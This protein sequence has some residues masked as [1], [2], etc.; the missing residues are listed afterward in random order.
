[1]TRVI[2]TKVEIEGR[3]HE[4]TV[5][6]EEDEPKAWEE[7]RQF[8]V[9]GKGVNRVDGRERVTGAARYTYDISLPG[10]LSAAVL[11]SPHAHAR[12][13]SIDTSHAAQLPGVRAIVS[14]ENTDIDWYKGTARL[15]D[16]TL[17]FIGDDVAAVAADDLDIARD[18]LK[19]IKVEYE[20]LPALLT[21][22]E[23]SRPGAPEIHPRG[24]IIQ[25]NGHNG[26]LYTRGSV[27][28]GFKAAEVTVE[29]TYRTSTQ[30]HNS[31]ETH[32]S[33]A[34]WEGEE[35]TL[36][37]STQYIFGV[38]E[39]VAKALDMPLSKV[40]VI[41]EYMGGGFGSKGSTFKQAA[42]A[43]LLA[44]IAQRPVKLMLD[45]REENTV[46]GNRGETVQKIRLGAT[47][48]GFLTAI[49]LEAMTG[50]GIYA[51]WAASVAGPAQELYRC[52]NVRTLTL[53]VRTNMGSQAAFRAPGY[54]EGMF[55]LE[56]AVDDLCVQAGH[57]P[58]RLSAEKPFTS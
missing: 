8:S 17:R 48:D 5:V 29:G 20:V 55:A 32:G 39:R 16:S 25:H 38:R 34:M 41:C 26:E 44:R 28:K 10:M 7:G 21:I 30:M 35:L 24:N 57:G 43:A 36:W 22:E 13:I 2:K 23:A 54:V 52:E 9:V 31:L 14:M 47:R 50:V 58:C 51:T 4:E 37:E 49:D 33:V 15:F 42:I 19:L 12:I 27:D 1:M 6:V 40:R 45:R 3:V 18:A 53:G 56:S 11:R 46:A